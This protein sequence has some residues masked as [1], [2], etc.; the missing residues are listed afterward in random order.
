M[1]FTFSALKMEISGSYKIFYLSSKLHG[2]TSHTTIISMELVP[3]DAKGSA[4]SSKGY[5]WIQCCNGYFEI[6][7]FY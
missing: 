6:D 3:V 2:V 1:L 4:D 5:P 7:L